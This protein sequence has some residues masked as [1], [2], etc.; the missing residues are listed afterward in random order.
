VTAQGG[1]TAHAAL[2]AR[3]MGKPCVVGC[4]A[5]AIDP[6]SRTARFNGGPVG[7]S[8]WISID[9]DDGAVYSGHANIVRER[10]AAELAELERWRSET[11]NRATP[12]G[13]ATTEPPTARAHDRRR[14]ASRKVQQRA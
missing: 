4:T 12:H 13:N 8:D 7:E 10:P 1:R 6:D 14:S 9:G 2:V 11:V 5:L 3:Q